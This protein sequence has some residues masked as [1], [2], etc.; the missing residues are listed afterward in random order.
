MGPVHRAISDRPVSAVDRPVIITDNDRAAIR[1]NMA[2]TRAA[3]VVSGFGLSRGTEENDGS[4][5]GHQNGK[6]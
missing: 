1:L 4:S 3:I 5:K 6:D 2:Y